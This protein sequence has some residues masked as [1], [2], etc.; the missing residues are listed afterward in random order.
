MGLFV[1]GVILSKLRS[2]TIRTI[3]ASVQ[4]QRKSACNPVATAAVALK[5][6]NDPT[7]LPRYGSPTSGA[8]FA[9]MV[10]PENLKL[11]RFG[12][13]TTQQRLAA[14][15]AIL[16]NLG[17][18]INVYAAATTQKRVFDSEL[19]ELMRYLLNDGSF[20]LYV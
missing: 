8:V 16:Q 1:S 11:S 17:S 15:T 18:I 9:R 6:L 20:S 13:L 4:W 14:A 3:Q 12:T 2:Y 10:S 19:V 5:S 7:Q